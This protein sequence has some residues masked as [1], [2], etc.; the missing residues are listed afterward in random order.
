M[1]TN[2]FIS[3]V[4]LLLCT[5]LAT[6]VQVVRGEASLIGEANE[7]YFSVTG[8]WTQPS[9]LLA[10]L[11]KYDEDKKGSSLWLIGILPYGLDISSDCDYPATVSTFHKSEK[12]LGSYSRFGMMRLF[13]EKDKKEDQEAQTALWKY[14]NMTVPKDKDLGCMGILRYN[15]RM[16]AEEFPE[17]E[18]PDIIPLFTTKNK[19]THVHLSEMMASSHI[20]LGRYLE[21]EDDLRSF[22]VDYMTIGKIPLVLYVDPDQ[23]KNNETKPEEG[24]D[25]MMHYQ[26]WNTLSNVYKFQ[27]SFAFALTQNASILEIPSDEKKDKS[28]TYI[29]VLPIK[30]E[31]IV[32]PYDKDGNQVADVQPILAS[33]NEKFTELKDYESREMGIILYSLEKLKK[34]LEMIQ[35]HTPSGIRKAL[36]K[37]YDERN[38]NETTTTTQEGMTYG[39]IDELDDAPVEDMPLRPEDMMTPDMIIDDKDEEDGEGN[40]SDYYNSRTFTDEEAIK[41]SDEEGSEKESFEYTEGLDGLEGFFGQPDDFVPEGEKEEGQ[42]EE[43]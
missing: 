10:D 3:L 36:K 6:T 7:D 38:A 13:G 14:L 23:T 25:S 32:F 42:K 18:N 41:A 12:K 19:M 20:F 34:W 31:K 11:K 22:G 16:S 43:L 35:S 40:M 39:T 2:K 17:A 1:A 15:A 29:A 5:T 26:L 9:E 8:G 24:K 28:P 33:L 21:S 30:K 4:C 37:K 27:Q